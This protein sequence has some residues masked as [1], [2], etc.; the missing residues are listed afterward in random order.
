M[1]EILALKMDK[2]KQVAKILK[3]NNTHEH[4]IVFLFEF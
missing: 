2:S 1:C 3:I 4:F